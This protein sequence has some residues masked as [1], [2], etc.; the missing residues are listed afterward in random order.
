MPPLQNSPRSPWLAT[1]WWLTAALVA[2]RLLPM[3]AER[4]MF[5][6]GTIYATLSRNMAIGEG[7]MWHPHFAF[8]GEAGYCEMPTLALWL[9]SFAFRLFG[10]HFWVEKLYSALAGLATAGVLAAIWRLLFRDDNKLAALSWLPVA[11]WAC[12]PSWSWMYDN[13]LL[14]NPLGLF[15]AMSVYCSVRAALARATGKRSRPVLL[16][17]VAS[18]V[19]LAAGIMSKGP[20]GLF[21]LIVPLTIALTLRWQRPLAGVLMSAAVGAVAAGCIALLLMQAG[22]ADYMS[23]Y[24][25]VQVARS[26]A[27]DRGIVHS[28]LGRFDVLWRMVQQLVV[29]GAIAWCLIAWARRRVGAT[30]GLSS[31]AVCN[32][33]SKP[34]LLDKPAVA[35]VCLFGL[36]TGLSASLPIALSP[37]QSGHYA[38]PSY[39]FFALGLSAWCAP[40]VAGLLASVPAFNWQRRL[41]SAAAG[42]I[43][44]L[45]AATVALAGHV[46]RDKD[47]LHDTLEIGRLL[48]RR[49][50]V[51]AGQE[52]AHDFPLHCYLSRWDDVRVDIG[53][54]D[55]EY[56]V[57][58]RSDAAPPAGFQTVASDLVAYQLYRRIPG[59]TIARLP[60]NPAA[61]SGKAGASW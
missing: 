3:I 29:P 33:T 46:H 49:T 53:S 56:F 52:L 19:C 6:D 25:H 38:F 10:D 23:R 2:A 42:V 39:A 26:L 20:V 34:S 57:G 24:L 8:G 4:G 51:G 9:D 16:W 18:G 31:S 48:P 45:I 5:Q 17:I 47:L 41:R 44:L 35:P 28:P 50:T 14:E 7:D 59:A 22:A 36:L 13:N 37:R 30:A 21:P 58:P 54:N 27:G 15:A 55:Y 60:R 32:A 40:A 43:G 1:G 11:L 12:I 61:P